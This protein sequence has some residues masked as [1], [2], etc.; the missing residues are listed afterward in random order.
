MSRIKDKT[1]QR[2]GRLTVRKLHPERSG[3]R[4]AQWICLCDCS[5]S[6]IV[7]GYDLVSGSTVSCGCKRLDNARV[8]GFKHG[9]SKDPVYHVW[10]QMLDRCN[11]PNNAS[12]EAYGGRGIKVCLRWQGP[13]GFENFIADMGERPNGS[14]LERKKNNRGY[15][16]RNCEWA[17]AVVQSNNT[18]RNRYVMFRGRKLTVAQLA[19]HV[20]IPPST[21]WHRLVK[22][23]LSVKEAVNVRA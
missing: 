20:N 18:R 7:C 23:G 13:A 12:Y 11:N 5:V 21:L 14:L 9:R 15:T 10:Q 4:Q 1:G 3:N 17:S 19:R 16:P 2:Y 8:A 6:V 22:Q